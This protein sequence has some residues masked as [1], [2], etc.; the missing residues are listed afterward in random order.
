MQIFQVRRADDLS[1]VVPE[2]V[3]LDFL[4]LKAVKER[5][6][7]SELPVVGLGQS[8][9]VHIMHPWSTISDDIVF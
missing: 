7:E 6:L 5:S 2:S 4:I 8:N 1:P 3:D 9:L